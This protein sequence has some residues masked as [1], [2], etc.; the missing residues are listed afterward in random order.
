[1]HMRCNQQW[2]NLGMRYLFFLCAIS[3][4]VA[5][6]P[7]SYPAVNQ[8]AAAQTEPIYLPGKRFEYHYY[9][10]T[11]ERSYADVAADGSWAS[12]PSGGP[13]H[14]TLL[15]LLPD[16]P[17]KKTTRPEP[18]NL[19]YIHQDF[20]KVEQAQLVE[21]SVNTWLHPP[22]VAGLKALAMCPFMYLRHDLPEG[23]FWKDSTVI[24][25]EWAD[26]RWAS[27]KGSLQLS[28]SYQHSGKLEVLTPFGPLECTMVIAEGRSRVGNTRLDALYHP[29]Y[30]FISGTYSL[31]SGMI[32]ILQLFSVREV[33]LYHSIG[34]LLQ[35]EQLKP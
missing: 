18:R 3:T 29:D 4:V 33:P 28:F 11:P 19:V 30:G 31:P 23:A 32:I 20:K 35:A 12:Q 14:R 27:W 15:L 10:L 9:T 8:S 24:S 13:T 7:R 5:C 22:Q 17:K 6:Q 26:P 21:N 2:L 25:D 1:M 16:L 34:E